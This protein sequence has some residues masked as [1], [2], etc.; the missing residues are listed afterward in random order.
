MGVAIWRIIK[1]LALIAVCLASAY[2]SLRTRVEKEIGPWDQWVSEDS[3]PADGNFQKAR[4]LSARFWTGVPRSADGS[5]SRLDRYGYT[6]GYSKDHRG[7]VWAST[8][9]PGKKVVGNTA[10][11][12]GIWKDDSYLEKMGI[13]VPRVALTGVSQLVPSWLMDSFYN[14]PDDTWYKSNQLEFA[15][16][17]AEDWNAHLGRIARWAVVYDGVVS[18]FGPVKRNDERVGFFSLTLKRGSR[19]PEAVAFLFEEVE[20]GG[21]KGGTTT[22]QAI[23]DATEL[24]FFADL[25]AEWRSYLRKKPAGKAWPD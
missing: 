3:S 7:V 19:G 18:F 16:K 21:L 9:L 22:I 8:F 17:T 15:K 13:E 25:P 5:V 6:L 14:Y 24:R 12:R 1:I 11:P 4:N 2:Y 20:G 23:E 10:V